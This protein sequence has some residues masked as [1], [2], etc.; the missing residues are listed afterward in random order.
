MLARH[1]GDG[2]KMTVNRL[3]IVAV[4]QNHFASIARAH[5]CVG[6]IAVRRGAYRRAIRRIDIEARVECAFTVDRVFA[7][8]K[9]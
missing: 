4:I 6:N 7:L 1:H 3:D 2:G 8:A 9:A 5:G